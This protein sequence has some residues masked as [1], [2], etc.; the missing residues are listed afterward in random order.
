MTDLESVGLDIAQL[1]VETRGRYKFER[2]LGQGAYGIVY[3]ALDTITGKHVAVKRVGE[4][5]DSILDAKRTLRE[6]KILANLKHE[7]IT[8]LV[9]V[10]ATNNFSKFNTLIVV[11]D[12]MDTDLHQ[13]IYSKQKLSMD[14]RRYFMYQILRGLKYVHSANILH[15]DLKPS[16][17]LVNSNCDLK[18]C[19]FGLARIQDEHEFLSEYVTTR[20]YRAPEVLLGIGKYGPAM[21]MWSVGC[22]FYELIMRKPLFPGRSCLNQLSVIVEKIG[23]PTN[24]DLAS[25]TSFKARK[26]MKSIP[27][28]PMVNWEKLISSATKYEIDLIQKMLTWDPTK[29]I[30]ADEAIEH[31]YFK[32]LHDPFDEPVT[33]PMD[34]FN[35]ENN[36]VTMRQMKQYIWDEV[37]LYHPKNK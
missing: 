37:C 15:R 1:E 19:D 14:H 23:S 12:L 10:T 16:N 31:P 27:H 9:D 30:L 5:F 25:I 18:I 24:E 21:D 26:Y 7:N 29:R 32:N 13:I 17:L 22:I 33:Y 8:N 11:L 6:I 3:A 28:R 35:F 34:D 36:S 2:I 4:I 20:W